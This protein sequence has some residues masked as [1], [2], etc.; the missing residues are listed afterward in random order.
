MAI[1][2]SRFCHYFILSGWEVQ[3]NSDMTFV[4]SNHSI[5]QTISGIYGLESL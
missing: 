4:I 2:H 3:G 5:C 1:M